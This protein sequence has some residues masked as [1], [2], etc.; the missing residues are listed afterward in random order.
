E[1]V[2]RCEP[3]K[4]FLDALGPEEHDLIGAGAAGLDEQAIVEGPRVAEAQRQDPSSTL[5]GNLAG[6]TQRRRAARM[7][8]ARGSLQ[9]DDDVGHQLKPCL[10][11]T[12][13]S[14][15]WYSISKVSVPSCRCLRCLRT[16]LSKS[17]SCCMWRRRMSLSLRRS[18]GSSA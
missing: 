6:Q 15:F 9:V 4:Q 1:H 13:S 18:V 11:F 14:C 12:S 3:P 10:R 2:A 5:V 7:Q 17:S 8:A 16:S